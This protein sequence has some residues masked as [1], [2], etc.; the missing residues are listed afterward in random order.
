MLT[1]HWQHAKPPH[2]KEIMDLHPSK[3]RA[4][5]RK[6][7]RLRERERESNVRAQ[8]CDSIKHSPQIIHHQYMYGP[9]S[10]AGRGYLLIRRIIP[11]CHVMIL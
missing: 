10:A 6:Q 9:K 2:A 5:I 3:G 8:L 11:T 7:R 1:L 4:G